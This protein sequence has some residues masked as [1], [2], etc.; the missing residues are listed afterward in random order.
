MVWYHQ[1]RIKEGDE[2]KTAFRIQFGHFQYRVM[3]FGLCKAP[4]TFQR[5]MNDI[6]GKHLNEF[7]LVHLIYSHTPEQHLEHLRVVLSLLRQKMLYIKRSKYEFAVNEIKF[8]GC[9]ATHKG[10]SIDPLKIKAIIDWPPPSGPPAQCKTQL[11]AFLGLANFNQRCVNHFAEPAA[12]LNELTS[13]KAEWKWDQ[14][15]QDAFDELK[16]RMIEK[17]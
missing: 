7:V 1:V 5:L 10:I 16:R 4:A 11:R 12:P 13:E 8:L 14:E 3:P 9:I 6:F 15:Q 17:P 2:Y